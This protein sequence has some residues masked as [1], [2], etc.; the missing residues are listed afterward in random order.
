MHDGRPSV[1]AYYLYADHP[2]TQHAQFFGRRIGQIDDP[3]LHKGPPVIDANYHRLSV[4]D[5][6]HLHVG[7]EGQAPMGR[8]VI[9][10]VVAFAA[11]RLPDAV[12]AVRIVARNRPFPDGI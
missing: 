1:H 5:A 11:G 6:C 7:A 9:I 10:P 2:F 8:C 12:E 3:A 4:V